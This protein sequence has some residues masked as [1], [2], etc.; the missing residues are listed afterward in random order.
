[1]L[2]TFANTYF[3]NAY[4]VAVLKATLYVGQS[5]TDATVRGAE[6]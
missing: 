6:F 5:D 2:L 3:E 1:M 4:L